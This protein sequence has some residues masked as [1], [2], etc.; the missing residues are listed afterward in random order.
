MDMESQKDIAKFVFQKSPDYRVVSANGIVGA[1]TPQGQVKFDLFIDSVVI[2]EFIV[3]KVRP[4]GFVGE[5]IE[6]EPSG[7]V[8]TRELQVGVLLPVDVA[9]IIANWILARVQEI[10][11]RPSGPS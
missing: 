11:S 6:K 4:D 9:E 7:R 1:M 2:P 5:E 10:K 3:Y 8:I